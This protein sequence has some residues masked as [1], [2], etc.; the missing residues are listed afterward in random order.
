MP[1]SARIMRRAKIMIRIRII[2]V[3][4]PALVAAACL[5]GCSSAPAPVTEPPILDPAT[6]KADY[7]LAKPS[8]ASLYDDSYDRLWNACADTARSEF[9]DLDRQDYRDGLLTT[10]PLVSKQI[11]EFWRSDAGDSYYAMQDSVQTIRRSIQFEF[12]KQAGGGTVS[13]KVLIERFAQPNRRITS[14]G[15]YRR[16]F[17]PVNTGT[18]DPNDPYGNE[19]QGYWYSIGRDYAM[20]AEL[21]QAIRLRL[22]AH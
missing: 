10:R 5:L 12:D 13:P 14:T 1:S 17:A 11:W 6:A 2:S 18:A 7:W 3:I 22:P 21:V 4:A 19:D 8:A 15:D 9:F 20:E 16:V